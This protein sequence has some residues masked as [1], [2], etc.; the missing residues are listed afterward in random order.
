M[1]DF[2]AFGSLFL[3]IILYNLLIFLMIRAVVNRIFISKRH[4]KTCLV[5]GAIPYLNIFVLAYAIYYLFP[6]DV[7]TRI[8]AIEEYTT[9]KPRHDG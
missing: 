4:R 6:K 7:L 5:L 3:I 1:D 8:K 9:K 2:I